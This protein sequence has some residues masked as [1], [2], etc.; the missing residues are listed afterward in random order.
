MATDDR[1]EVGRALA[2]FVD[3]FTS[4]DRVLGPAI[5]ALRS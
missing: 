2:P 5:E 3:A 4:F 1:G